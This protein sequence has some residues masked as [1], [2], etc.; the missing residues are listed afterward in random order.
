MGKKLLY[1]TGCSWIFDFSNNFEPRC[2]L[3]V[4]YFNQRRNLGSNFIFW[5]SLCEY[6]VEMVQYFKTWYFKVGSYR[7]YILSPCHYIFKTSKWIQTAYLVGFD[8]DNDSED[9]LILII[10]N[11]KYLAFKFGLTQQD[12]SVK[13]MTI[14]WAKKDRTRK[15]IEHMAVL[16]QDN[17]LTK[18]SPH[19]HCLYFAKDK[20]LLHSAIQAHNDR[21][22]V[23]QKTFRFFY[24]LNT[25]NKNI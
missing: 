13:E 3:N 7:A 6:P 24:G 25:Y 2:N 10:Y 1:S 12:L 9:Y 14:F 5:S 16:S 19:I 22:T 20:L 8:S 23:G 17:T 21:S 11:G 18:Y 15:D 4:Q